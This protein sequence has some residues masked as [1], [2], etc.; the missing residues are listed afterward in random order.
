MTD[1]Q[2]ELARR[3]KVATVELIKRR[4]DSIGIRGCCGVDGRVRPDN[5]V[6]MA[7]DFPDLTDPATLGCLLAL[8]RK[9]WDDPEAYVRTQPR[10]GRVVW[11]VY[12]ETAGAQISRGPAMDSE[13]LM[14]Y[15]PTEAHALVAALEA[16]P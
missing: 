7:G 6:A 8:V 5:A 16:A 10:G 1:E 14:L 12:V 2:Q 4:L 9:A 11:V 13:G 3:A 15:G